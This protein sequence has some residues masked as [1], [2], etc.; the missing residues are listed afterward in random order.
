MIKIL[1]K[2]T[3]QDFDIWLARFKQNAPIRRSYGSQ[4]A[5][6]FRNPGDAREALVYFTWDSMDNAIKFT[7]DPV[8]LDT[9]EEIGSGIPLIITDA[10]EVDG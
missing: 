4:S 1:V 7:Q 9:A 6:V 10:I 5:V 8:F 3:F 2:Q